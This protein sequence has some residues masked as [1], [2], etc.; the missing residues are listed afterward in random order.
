[1][2]FFVSKHELFFAEMS[3]E[4]FEPLLQYMYTGDC[5]IQQEIAHDVCVFHYNSCHK[6]KLLEYLTF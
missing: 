1:M 2:D 6:M 5:T 4:V 3:L